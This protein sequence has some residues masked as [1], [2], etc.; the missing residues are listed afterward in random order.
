M[1]EVDQTD[2]RANELLVTGGVFA[3][4]SAHPGVPQCEPVFDEEG[5]AQTAIYLWLDFM[6][7]RYRLTI[8]MDPED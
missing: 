4:L 5:N 6:K 1:A 7:S 8:T 3:L 2:I